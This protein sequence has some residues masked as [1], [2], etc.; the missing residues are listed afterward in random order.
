M[1]KLIH[2]E[3]SSF[4]ILGGKAGQELAKYKSN[5]K[6]AVF[7]LNFNPLPSKLS[8]TCKSK[9]KFPK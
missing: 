4:L 1:V 6:G 2:I 5:N 7:G 8:K 9:S 3:G